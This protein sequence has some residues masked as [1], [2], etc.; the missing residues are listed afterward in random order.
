MLQFKQAAE[1][2]TFL[3]AVFIECEDNI[4]ENGAGCKL[5]AGNYICVCLPGYTGA[6]C[7]GEGK[8]DVYIK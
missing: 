5:L 1:N 3:N 7:E 6:F 4:C 8:W 2:V